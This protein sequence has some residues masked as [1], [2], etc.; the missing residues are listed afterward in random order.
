[1]V[2][3][4]VK[5]RMVLLWLLTGKMRLGGGQGS[6]SKDG[7]SETFDRWD[8]FGCWSKGSQ[9]RMVFLRLQTGKMRLGGGQGSQT[10]DGASEA[11]DR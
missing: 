8:A 1:M 5:P 10:K 6:Q 9:P 4:A 3:R 2:A 11:S 7:A